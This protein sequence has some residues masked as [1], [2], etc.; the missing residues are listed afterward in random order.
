MGM[1]VRRLVALGALLAAL[2]IFPAAV[3][4]ADTPSPSPSAQTTTPSAGADEEVDSPDVPLDETRTMLAL[5]GA[6]VLAVVAG[7]VVLLRR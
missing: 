2:V 1:C 3:A 7:T 6:G 4:A 5:V